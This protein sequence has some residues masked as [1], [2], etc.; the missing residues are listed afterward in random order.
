MI[1][2]DDRVNMSLIANLEPAPARFEYFGGVT[3]VHSPHSSISPFPHLDE[4]PGGVK[5]NP[6]VTNQKVLEVAYESWYM[7]RNH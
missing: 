6:W 4:R 7:M 5:Q 3:Y 1:V 2:I